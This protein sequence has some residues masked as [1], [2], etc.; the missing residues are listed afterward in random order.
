M[1]GIIVGRRFVAL[2]EISHGRIF[3]GRNE[4]GTQQNSSLTYLYII[5]RENGHRAN[6]SPIDT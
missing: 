3:P 1:R 5:S 4:L 2:A 6:C